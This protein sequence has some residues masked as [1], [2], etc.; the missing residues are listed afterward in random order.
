LFLP[1][2][3][4][5]Y[6]SLS[7]LYPCVASFLYIFVLYLR[8][9][10]FT[11]LPLAFSFC[12]FLYYSLF[13]LVFVFT[14]FYLPIHI[15]FLLHSFFFFFFLLSW[16]CQLIQ[17]P[18]QYTTPVR[19]LSWTFPLL[20]VFNILSNRLKSATGLSC[21]SHSFTVPHKHQSYSCTCLYW[22]MR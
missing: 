17:A 13:C 2:S 11:Y 21:L 10:L 9:Y 16:V 15:Y 22:Q 20:D 19:N 1:L 4:Y 12:F 18:K 5:L 8:I 7:L 3:S 14:Y 6:P